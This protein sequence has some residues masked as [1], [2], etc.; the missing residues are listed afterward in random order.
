MTWMSLLPHNEFCEEMDFFWVE[1]RCLATED[2]DQVSQ[3][4]NT[5]HSLLYIHYLIQSWHRENR[6]KLWAVWVKCAFSTHISLDGAERMHAK[7]RMAVAVILALTISQ[8]TVVSAQHWKYVTFSQHLW[9]FPIHLT[10][11]A[12]GFRR[13]FFR[14]VGLWY[15]LEKCLSL[16]PLQLS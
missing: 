4:T 15:Y 3:S 8:S 13:F 9:R 6:L 16:A 2:L 7:A 12:M 11:C 5:S 14:L 1:R 10:G